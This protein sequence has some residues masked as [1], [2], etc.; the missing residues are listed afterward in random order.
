[1]G[2]IGWVCAPA[3]K[4]GQCPMDVPSGVTAVPTCSLKQ[5]VLKCSPGQC[6]VG[7]G[8]RQI[9]GYCTYDKAADT[10]ALTADAYALTNGAEAIQGTDDVYKHDEMRL[11]KTHY[12]NPKSGCRSDEHVLSASIGWVCTPACKSGECPMDVPSGVTAVP[13]CGLKQCVLKCSPGQC[14]VGARCRQI[15]G[16]CTYDKA[17]DTTALTADATALTKVAEAIQGPGNVYK[18][19]K[20]L[21]QKI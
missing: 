12:G 16:Y 3:C 15:E 1:M 8:C 19:D 6:G 20:M 13:T 7:A 14:G 21:L 11:Q 2:S 4:S 17:A 18:H 5:C 10:T 9:E